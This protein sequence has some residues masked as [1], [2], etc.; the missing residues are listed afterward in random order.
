MNTPK[1]R[2]P[3]E[4][5]AI[6]GAMKVVNT[7]DALVQNED[8]QRFMKQHSARAD[9]LAQEILHDDMEPE[10]REALRNR[11]LGLLEVLLAPKQDRDAQVGVLA[12]FGV[13]PGDPQE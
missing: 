10:K 13:H 4:Q 9:Q 3:E 1:P 5:K 7:I 11:R 6:D 8:F 12:R 2:T